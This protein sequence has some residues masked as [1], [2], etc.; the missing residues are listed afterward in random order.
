MGLY[1]IAL[2]F[3]FLIWIVASVFIFLAVAPIIKRKRQDGYARR[4]T[5][6]EEEIKEYKKDEAYKKSL[7]ENPKFNLD[8]WWDYHQEE[9]N[10]SLIAGALIALVATVVILG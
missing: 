8:R 9:I 5:F 7:E 3:C 2:L 4:P 6:T 10:T 1:F